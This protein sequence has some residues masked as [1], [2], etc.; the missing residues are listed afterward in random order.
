VQKTVKAWLFQEPPAAVFAHRLHAMEGGS[1]VLFTNKLTLL[2]FLSPR[3]QSRLT[4]DR[5]PITE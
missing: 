4:T 2:Q 5:I 3:E 1:S